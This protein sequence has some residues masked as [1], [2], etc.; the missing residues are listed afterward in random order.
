MYENTILRAVFTTVSMSFSTVYSIHFEKTRYAG[1]ISVADC[2]RKMSARGLTCA[3]DANMRSWATCS[4]SRKYSLH[5]S[6]KG[7]T[8]KARV[9]K[10]AA[11]H[12]MPINISDELAHKRKY[13]EEVEPF[14]HFRQIICQFGIGKTII[15][16]V[17]VLTIQYSAPY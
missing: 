16:V 12:Y 9:S 8:M 1:C 3:F 17:A 4:R 7:D 5:F 6:R 14:H 2:P 15:S 11:S 13:I 10:S